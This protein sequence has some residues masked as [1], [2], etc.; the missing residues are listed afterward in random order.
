MAMR[1]KLGPK[2]GLVLALAL[3]GRVDADTALDC[4][5][6]GD[7]FT[8][9][10]GY[11]LTLPPAPNVEASCVAKDAVLRAEGRPRITVGQLHLAGTGIDGAPKTLSLVIEGL[12][13]MPELR[14]RSMDPRLRAALRLQTVDVRLTLRQAT[15][16]AGL[17]LR[18]GVIALSGGTE[19]RIEADLQGAGFGARSLPLSLLTALNLEWKTDGRL[20][21][22]AMEAAGERLEEGATGDTA[23]A[24]ARQALLVVIGN[25][26]EDA[27]TG[28]TAHELVALVEALPQG[29]GRMVL[30][31]D[32]EAGIGAARLAMAALSDDP[33]GQAAL[34]KLF[35]GTALSVDWQPGV[36]N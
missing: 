28:D 34:A 32:A 8:A 30:A 16:F 7:I 27:L 11:S 24:L 25:L 15:G 14:D 29:R 9:V 36:A 21:R 18:D 4:R 19:L 3:A 2:L 10:T 20:P 1:L 22:P 17:E 35:A 26:P 31:F 12:R 6:L 13:V 33:T 5:A 23:V